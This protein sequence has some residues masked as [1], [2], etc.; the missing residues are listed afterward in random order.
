MQ[1]PAC[2]GRDSAQR[3][4]KR[5]ALLQ[6]RSWP[7]AHTAPHLA[8]CLAGL[9]GHLCAPESSAQGRRPGKRPHGRIGQRKQ[10]VTAGV[11]GCRSHD[12]LHRYSPA[13]SMRLRRMPHPTFN[14]GLRATS[15]CQSAA[16]LLPWLLHPSSFCPGVSRYRCRRPRPR[17]QRPSP[18]ARCRSRKRR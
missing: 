5:P 17:P 16:A 7:D 12:A 18:W 4:C 3:R 11:T 6:Q 9:Q 8:A 15:V 1:T 2:T 14:A 13:C 10:P